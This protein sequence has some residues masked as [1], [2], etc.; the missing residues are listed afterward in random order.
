M[1]P[2]AT[3][4]G[5]AKGP[6]SERATIGGSS[7]DEQRGVRTAI[8]KR[9]EADIDE[10][11][12]EHDADESEHDGKASSLRRAHIF[13]EYPISPARLGPSSHRCMGP[14]LTLES[15][16]NWQILG[17]LRGQPI[18]RVRQFDHTG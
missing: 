8:F 14:D 4:I 9:Q 13:F 12:E 16:R 11:K 6:Q 5:P 2:S 18:D 10:Q 15:A 7:R 17:P 3:L 1:T